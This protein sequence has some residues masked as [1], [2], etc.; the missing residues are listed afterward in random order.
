MRRKKIYI[1][2]NTDFNYFQT[3]ANSTRWEKYIYILLIW[4]NKRTERTVSERCQPARIQI[5]RLGGTGWWTTLLFSLSRLL[6]SL[7]LVLRYILN[8]DLKLPLN[9][10]K[11]MVYG[12]KISSTSTL[13][14]CRSSLWF[15]YSSVIYTNKANDI[16]RTNNRLIYFVSYL[17]DIR[18]NDF[19]WDHGCAYVW[20]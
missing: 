6:F 15:L 5:S 17:D 19:I 14:R 12:H 9:E 18:I 7:L 8:K 10:T 2:K 4:H 13:S 16:Y 20:V 1:R 3:E 11:K